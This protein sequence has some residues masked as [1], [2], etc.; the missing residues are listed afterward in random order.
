MQRISN[1]SPQI[2]KIGLDRNLFSNIKLNSYYDVEESE[3]FDSSQI[4]EIYIENLLLK[5]TNNINKYKNEGVMCVYDERVFEDVVYSL[6]FQNLLDILTFDET[7]FDNFIGDG[8]GKWIE[9]RDEAKIFIN[10]RNENNNNTEIEMNNNNN[11]NNGN[12]DVFPINIKSEN[13]FT[14]LNGNIDKKSRKEFFESQKQAISVEFE[15]RFESGNLRMGLQVTEYE[16]DLILKNDINSGK[17][18]NWFFFRVNLKNLKKINFSENPQLLKF[19]IINCLKI[20]TLFSKGLKVLYYIERLKKWYRNTKNNYYYS[21]SLVIE[22][23]KLHSLTFS[24]ELNRDFDEETLYFSYCYPYTFSYLQN[25]L[26]SILN[27]QCILQK[28]IIRHEVIGKSLA[29][30]NLD[31]LIITK[32]ESAFEDI[33]YRPCIILTSRVHPGESNSSFVIQGLIDFLLE[34]NN[35]IAETLKKTFIFKIV[36]M[37]NPDGVINGNFRTSLIGKDLNRL[38]DDPRENICPTIFFTKEMI[39]KTLLSRDIFL[40]CD[41]HGHSNKPNFFLYG[42]PSN[43]KI[44]INSAYN[45]L[46][47]IIAKFYSIK[48]DIFDHK[49]CIYKIIAKKL[50]TARAVLKNEFNIDLSYCLESS[51][52]H[53]TIGEKKSDF[54]TPKIYEKIGRD[55]CLSI[56]ELQEKNIF[57]DILYK[58]QNE[59]NIKANSFNNVPNNGNINNN[60][61]HTNNFLS[62]KNNNI[63]ANGDELINNKKNRENLINLNVTKPIREKIKEREKTKSINNVK[64]NNNLLNNNVQIIMNQQ[65][66]K[67][68]IKENINENLNSEK[69]K[70]QKKKLNPIKSKRLLVTNNENEIQ[71]QTNL[72]NI[73]LNTSNSLNVNLNINNNINNF[74][75]GLS[76][77]PSKNN[78]SSSKSLLDNSYG[79]INNKNNNGK[80]YSFPY[81]ANSLNTNININYASLNAVSI[82]D[83]VNSSC[84]SNQGNNN[85]IINTEEINDRFKNA[86]LKLNEKLNKEK[87]YV[88]TNAISAKLLNNGNLKNET[89]FSTIGNLNKGFTDPNF[90][91]N[92]ML[93]NNS[94]TSIKNDKSIIFN[95]RNYLS[96]SIKINSNNSPITNSLK[97]SKENFN[98]LNKISKKY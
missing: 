54:L 51:I 41:F 57:N 43:K 3:K 67:E 22:E 73:N 27:N 68:E 26:A 30:N 84:K 93:R 24:I 90:T 75:T 79:A 52:G 39:K 11:N 42:C 80:Q 72:K 82:L 95:N 96:S 58:L 71:V 74:N 33:A 78:S 94:I 97:I 38:W 63:N 9:N 45:F 98:F 87:I 47:M 77:Y 64:N 28:N 88:K 5:N 31:M 65:I 60:S 70:K 2:P 49:S 15:S 19:N 7:A 18:S 25:Y 6:N 53:I 83:N 50:K 48:N 86:S 59:E 4:D 69:L 91:E 13:F 21:N 17:T 36:P 29:G 34:N 46:E 40:F 66:D 14:N 76:N 85:S 61:I 81:N 16:Y 20:D 37:L 44:K 32:F 92:Q 23:K 55:F 89:I 8:K 35:T 62:N 56:F 12:N 1:F 10:N